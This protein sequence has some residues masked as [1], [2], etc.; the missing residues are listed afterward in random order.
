MTPLNPIYSDPSP[1]WVERAKTCAMTANS[2]DTVEDADLADAIDE[3]TA[4]PEE[5]AYYRAKY[6]EGPGGSE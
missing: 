2:F 5:L 1:K 6:G 3:G 4:T